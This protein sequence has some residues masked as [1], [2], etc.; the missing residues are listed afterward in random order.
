M[1]IHDLFQDIHEHSAEPDQAWAG[2]APASPAA[3]P[4]PLSAQEARPQR[5]GAVRQPRGPGA[6]VQRAQGP[7]QARQREHRDQGPPHR[8]GHQVENSL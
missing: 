6:R 2:A 4:G 1:Y 3:H 5:T 7:D 8:Q